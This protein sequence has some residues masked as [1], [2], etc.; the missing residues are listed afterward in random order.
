MFVYKYAIRYTPES[1]LETLCWEY[2][3]QSKEIE[4]LR[5]QRLSERYALVTDSL[6]KASGQWR[7]SVWG[8]TR[9]RATKVKT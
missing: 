6:M 3:Y 1:N 4:H 5:K 9:Q 7:H 8:P 2:I